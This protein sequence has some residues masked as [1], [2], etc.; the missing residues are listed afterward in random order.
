M[1]MTERKLWYVR[2]NDVVTGPFPER[3][4]RQHLLLGRLTMADEVSRDVQH[5]HTVATLDEIIPE[6]MKG[7]MDD[8]E[9]RQRFEAERRWADERLAIDRRTANGPTD[10]PERRGVERRGAERPETVVARELKTRLIVANR[11][12]KGPA[13]GVALLVA[14]SVLALL[15]WAATTIT[16]APIIEIVNCQ[17]APAPQVNWDS[18]QLKG[19]QWAG[20][21]IHDARARN[22]DLSGTTLDRANLDGADLAYANMSLT[23]IVAAS[24]RGATLVGADLQLSTLAESDFSGADLAYANLYRADLRGAKL[25]NVRLDRTVWVDGTICAVGSVGQ[26]T[27]SGERLHY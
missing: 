8:P 19:R 7:D 15:I 26:C 6:V 11:N 21:D 17:A 1:A 5:W 9:V 22:A 18:C 10:H 3:V 2:R 24:F 23:H 16:P 20:V 27:P 4:I 14:L 12:R 25:Q 13:N